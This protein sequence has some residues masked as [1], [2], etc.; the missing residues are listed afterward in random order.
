MGKEQ[1]QEN[2]IFRAVVSSFTSDVEGKMA[3]RLVMDHGN[4]ETRVMSVN[5]SL[6]NM[7]EEG[8]R[9]RAMGIGTGLSE[10]TVHIRLQRQWR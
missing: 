9:E 4:I 1:V 5:A 10:S 2:G 7:S 3:G 6:E 8:T